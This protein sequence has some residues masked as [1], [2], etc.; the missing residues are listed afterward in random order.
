MDY[1]CAPSWVLKFIRSCRVYI[2][3]SALF[4]TDHRLLV[5]N[6]VFPATKRELKKYAVKKL[7]PKPRT[8]FAALKES[9]E[10]Q[11]KLTIEIENELS[12]LNGESVDEINED[13]VN[14]VRNCVDRVCPKIQE[15]KKKE[16]WE[17]KCLQ[18]MMEEARRCTQRIETRKIHKKMKARRKWLKKHYFKELADDLNN[19]AEARQVEKEAKASL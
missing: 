6:I 10:L 5:T 19:V 7:N 2:G 8:N 11:E 15:Q 12:V 9:V 16:P 1:V 14:T 17:N 18:D 3:P 4:E 13:I